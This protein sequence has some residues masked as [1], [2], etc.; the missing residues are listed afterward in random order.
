MSSRYRDDIARCC[1]MALP[2]DVTIS[3]GHRTISSNGLEHRQTI[4]SSHRTISS[5]DMRLS[6]RSIM[7]FPE[8]P[9]ARRT[10]GNWISQGRQKPLFQRDSCP[11]VMKQ[12][13]PV[14]HRPGGH[15]GIEPG[16]AGC[17]DRRPGHWVSQGRLPETDIRGT[18]LTMVACGWLLLC[19]HPFWFRVPGPRSPQSWVWAQGPHGRRPTWA[20]GLL[21]PWAEHIL[22]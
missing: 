15:E 20:L 2:D 19:S 21:G 3:S 5:Y 10:R 14:F 17:G 18:D 7:A 6:L 13:F 16:R 12:W 1:P 11:K 22:G 4:S 8:F 9:E